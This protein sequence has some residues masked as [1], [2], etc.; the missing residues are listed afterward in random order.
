MTT[1]SPAAAHRRPVLD[2]EEEA[3]LSAL[4]DLHVLDTLPEERF[5]RVTRLARRLFAVDVALVTLLDRERQ[6][7]KSVSGD[8]IDVPEVPRTISFCDTTV[9]QGDS[10]VVEDLTADERFR[11]NPLVAV[12]SGLRFYAGHPLRAPGGQAVGTLC[13]LDH[14]PRGFT[15]GELETL[16]DLAA[17][18]QQELGVHE[19]YERAARVQRGLL[20]RGVPTLH[21]YQIAGACRPARAVGG[22]FFDWHPVRDGIAFTVA[23]VMGKGFAGAIMMA[24]VRAV[25]R[26]AWQHASASAALES[27]QQVLEDDLQETSTFVTLFHARLCAADGT[28]RFADAGHGLTLVVRADGTAERALSTGLPLGAWPNSTWEEREL[29]LQPGDALVSVSDGVL[30]LYDGTLSA[31]E[32]VAALVRDCPDAQTAVDRVVRV[33]RRQELVDDVT[34]L[35]VRRSDAEEER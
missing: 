4:E 27:A 23:D 8:G 12:D 15:D 28:V 30:D 18:V 11:T 22:D 2:L 16:R 14:Q 34:V 17:Y 26:S 25:L 29:H 1:A 3:R 35:V 32:Q 10:L 5:D 20:P 9:R 31:L 7:F 13:L 33:A 6:W 24:S 19:E 21:G